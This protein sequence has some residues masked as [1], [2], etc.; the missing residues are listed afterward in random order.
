[1]EL[2]AIGISGLVLGARS[3]AGLAPADA[4]ADTVEWA[5]PG[6]V[7]WTAAFAGRAVVGTLMLRPAARPAPQR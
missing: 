7:L 6:T 5:A 4:R 1:V 2:R 3:V